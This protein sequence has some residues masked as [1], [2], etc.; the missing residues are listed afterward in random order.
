VVV[1][2]ILKDIMTNDVHACIC[3]CQHC[4]WLIEA[5]IEC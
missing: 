4:L 5:T 3:G 2:L 1:M